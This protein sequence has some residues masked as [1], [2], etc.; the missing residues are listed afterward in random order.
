MDDLQKKP[1]DRTHYLSR[2]LQ[3]ML[4]RMMVE[5]PETLRREFSRCAEKHLHAQ[6]VSNATGRDVRG[7]RRCVGGYA[8]PVFLAGCKW[9]AFF[10]VRSLPF[11]PLLLL[12]NCARTHLVRG[13]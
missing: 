5:L 10:T 4:G 11:T 2:G 13:R 3:P 8:R 12:H 9:S 7:V 6:A 1:P